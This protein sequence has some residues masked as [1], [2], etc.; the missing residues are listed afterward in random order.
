MPARSAGPGK[1]APY[2][3]PPKRRPDMRL[4][5]TET[6]WTTMALA[7]GLE[8]AGL[9][10]TRIEDPADLPQFLGLGG[11]DAA[12][13]DSDL[14]GVEAADLVAELRRRDTAMPVAVLAP[15]GADAAA[16]YAAGADLVVDPRVP[17]AELASRLRAMVMRVRS[18][19]PPAIDL[20]GFRINPL[21]Q[22][23]VIGGMA[24]RLTPLEYEVVETLALAGGG[25]VDRTGLMDHLYAWENEPDARTLD[26]HMVHIRRKLAEAGA[27]VRIETRRGRG[28][29]LVAAEA[30]AKTTAEVPAPMALPLAA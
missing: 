16:L 1:A 12:V 28:F 19:C 18:F 26:V 3:Q 7:R 2:A 25:L 23:V 11:I 9:L 6:T 27:P 29:C 8:M 30:P 21:R 4:I 13:I 22:R 10:V 15:A 5:L 17:A 24:V 14:P 20:G